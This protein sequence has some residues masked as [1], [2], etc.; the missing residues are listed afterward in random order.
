MTSKY[1]KYKDYSISV[2]DQSWA[3]IRDLMVAM[4]SVERDA[5]IKMCV[6]CDVGEARTIIAAYDDEEMMVLLLHLR[7]AVAHSAAEFAEQQL[8]DGL[9]T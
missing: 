9:R 2:A 4:G 7:A 8:R 1:R 3:Q 6:T 5:F